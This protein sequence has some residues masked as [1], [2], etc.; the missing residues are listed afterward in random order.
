MRYSLIFVFLPA[1]LLSFL[2]L[3]PTFALAEGFQVTPFLGYRMGGYFEDAGTGLTLDLDEEE[4]WGIILGKDIAPG[5]QYEFFYSFQPSRL[6]AGGL[7]TPGVLVDVDVEY[8]HIG[9]R[10][11]WDKGTARTFVGGSVGATHF[12]PQSSNLSSETRFSLGLGGGVEVRAGEKVAIRLEG[13][14]FATFLDSSGAIFCGTSSGC[15]VFIASDVLWQFE[16]GAGVS[17][18]F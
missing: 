9:G 18:R 16:V 11:Y 12:D 6:T 13:K 14:G 17:F 3:T 2:L 4:S 15:E 5:K 8:F 10:N 7:V 1:V